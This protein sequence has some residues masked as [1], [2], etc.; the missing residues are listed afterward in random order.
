MEESGTTTEQGGMVDA[1][2]TKS[3]DGLSHVGTTA[4]LEGVNEKY[5]RKTAAQSRA[6][7]SGNPATDIGEQVLRQGGSICVKFTNATRALNMHGEILHELDG[8]HL[9]GIAETWCDEHADEGG[10]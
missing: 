3:L 10:A 8:T 5:V 9:L 6:A 2:V 4:C 1:E 7:A